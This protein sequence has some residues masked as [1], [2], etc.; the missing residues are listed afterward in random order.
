[1]SVKAIRPTR[2]PNFRITTR[3]FAVVEPFYQAGLRARV[4]GVVRSITKDIGEP[5]RAGELLVDVDAPDLRQAV[6]QKEAVI[7]QREKELAAATAD[8]AVAKNAVASAAVAVKL[9]AVEV[10]K[11][12]DTRAARKM[13]C[14]STPTWW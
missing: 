5:V 4:T 13:P 9:K 2:A 12:K 10:D 1:M 7:A 8:L 6:E 3:Q 11:A 14:G